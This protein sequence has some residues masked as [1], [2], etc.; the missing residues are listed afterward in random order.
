MAADEPTP[1]DNPDAKNQE[2]LEALWR[3]TVRALT[4]SIANPSDENN[5]QAARLEV[6]RKI[7][8]DNDIHLDSMARQTAQRRSNNAPLPFAENDAE[9]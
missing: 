4:E 7:L 6:A 5:A 3:A 1:D 8:A 2:A 9:E